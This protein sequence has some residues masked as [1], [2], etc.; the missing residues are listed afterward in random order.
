[1]SVSVRQKQSLLVLGRT[2]MD[3]LARL[4]H[5]ES[6]IDSS[7]SQQQLK[8]QGIKPVDPQ[9]CPDCAENCRDARVFLPL[10]VRPSCHYSQCLMREG[11]CKLKSIH[12]S[13]QAL[14]LTNVCEI[15]SVNAAVELTLLEPGRSFCLCVSKEK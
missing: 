11:I 15:R 3:E 7:K 1:M 9:T 10:L 4:C 12:F 2:T 13:L 5:Q 14:C 8:R 6:T